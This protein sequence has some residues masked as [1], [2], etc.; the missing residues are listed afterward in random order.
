METDIEIPE[1]TLR[2]MKDAQE[3]YKKIALNVANFIPKLPKFEIPSFLIPSQSETAY[4]PMDIVSE[5]N[6]WKRHEEILNVQS[7][8][9]EIQK[10]IL[11]EQ[12]STTK[13]TLW[14]F[15]LTI[16]GIIISLISIIAK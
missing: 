8:V 14:I 2:T 6:A 12:R 15:G 4:L 5:K 9:L 13:L 10:E 7:A 16:M 1:S 3:T 11:K